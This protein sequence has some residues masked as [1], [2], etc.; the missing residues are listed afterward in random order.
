MRDNMY[1]WSQVEAAFL[2][3]F[4]GADQE[5]VLAEQLRNTKQ[6]GRPPL[7]YIADVLQQLARL[8]TQPPFDR[9]R[10][11]DIVAGFDHGVRKQLRRL[12]DSKTHAAQLLFGPATPPF[13]Y[14]DMEKLTA[15]IAAMRPSDYMDHSGDKS[16]PKPSY[17]DD[18][19]TN[20][21][22]RSNKRRRYPTKT[23]TARISSVQP[24]LRSTLLHILH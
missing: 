12:A 8:G 22:Q 24:P 2:R 17:N 13:R 20:N 9:I 16:R 7:A 5:E 6:R 10:M 1:T 3:F 21:D 18:S 4:E 19:R 15:D 23:P 14:T 11:N